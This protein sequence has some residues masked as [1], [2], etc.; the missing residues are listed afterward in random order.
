MRWKLLRRRLSVSAPRMIVRSHLPWPVR[1]A[2]GAL[3]LG[4]SAA[5]ALWA[6]ETGKDLAGL[7]RAARAEL[8]KLRVEVAQLREEREKALSIA[9]TADSLLKTERTAQEKLAQQLRQAE[10]ENLALKADLGFF[11]T[12]LPAASGEAALSIRGLQAEPASEHQLRYQILLMQP[13][14][15]RPE[16]SG[17]YEMTLAGTLDGQPWSQPGGAQ[18]LQV[19]QYRR[20]EGLIE[21][22]PQAQVKTVTVKVTDAR[23]AVLASHSVQM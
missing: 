16:F 8:G 3:V 23:G 20:V 7:D 18:P 11:E 19:K 12:L 17:R 5:L 13:G 21:H 2:V 6:F 1:W 14:K 4:F 22:P 15:A 9:N 10:A